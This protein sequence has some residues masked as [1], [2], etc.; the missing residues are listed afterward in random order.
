MGKPVDIHAPIDSISQC[1]KTIDPVHA[2]IHDGQ[3]YTANHYVSVGT[4]TAVTVLITPP[5]V[6]S[7]KF[8][9][10]IAGVTT[11]NAGVFTF[12]E[13]PVTT[14][15][16]TL[17]SYNNYRDKQVDYPDPVVLKH[18]VTVDAA[19]IGTT[20][21]TFITAGA[22]TNEFTVGGSNLQRNEWLLGAGGTYLMRFSADNDSTRVV[23][24]LTYY[25]RDH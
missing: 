10:F 20:L 8:I 4:G 7:G 17:V 5:A 22:S 3:H 15:G 23:F 16:S 11:N 18:S 12:S 19:S 2:V 21:E 9:H 14:G 6:G 1:M 25:Y 13:N 24:N